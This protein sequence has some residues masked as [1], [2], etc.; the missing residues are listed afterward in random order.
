MVPNPEKPFLNSYVSLRN[1]FADGMRSK[2]N[3]VALGTRMLLISKC[4][5]IQCHIAVHQRGTGTCFWIHGGF[6][7]F[8]DRE[9]FIRE[10]EPNT[11][12]A[13]LSLPN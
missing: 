4:L 13:S 11:A 6:K 7:P 1:D 3:R 12:H 2:K 10:L 8:I 9:C 5:G